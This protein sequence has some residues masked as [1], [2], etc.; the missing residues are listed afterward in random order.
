M[1]ARVA[2]LYSIGVGDRPAALTH[3]VGHFTPSTHYGQ[4]LPAGALFLVSSFLSML[5][6]LR[7][8]VR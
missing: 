5:V 3:L 2:G 7:T 4:S 8:S 1:Q 6:E